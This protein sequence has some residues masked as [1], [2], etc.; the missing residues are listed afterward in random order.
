M[1]LNFK[2]FFVCISFSIA[3]MVLFVLINS[4]Y[5]KLCYGAKARTIIT[6]TI[7]LNTLAIVIAWLPMVYFWQEFSMKILLP[8]ACIVGGL[9]CVGSRFLY[10]E[11]VPDELAKKLVEFMEKRVETK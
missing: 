10:H 11:I 9:G 3:L 7:L 2:T 5:Y 4:S 6:R 1:S 8:V